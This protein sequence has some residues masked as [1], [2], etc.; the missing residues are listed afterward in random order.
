MLILFF[1]F[2]V[3][4]GMLA[5]IVMMQF[6]NKN[7]DWYIFAALGILVCDTAC[8]YALFINIYAMIH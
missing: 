6:M 2:S 1:I 5:G 4:Y 3:V 8:L 7:T